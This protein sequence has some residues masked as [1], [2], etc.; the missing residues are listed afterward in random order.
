MLQFNQISISFYTLFTLK[1][2][3]TFIETKQI[4]YIYT[5]IK[6]QTYLHNKIDHNK[7]QLK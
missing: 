4:F 1:V 6:S 3:L 7:L 5:G 2:H